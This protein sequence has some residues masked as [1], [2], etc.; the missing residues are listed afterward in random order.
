MKIEA[1]FL[2]VVKIE[3]LGRSKK[4]SEDNEIDQRDIGYENGRWM[5]LAQ[6]RVQW[7]ALVLALLNLWV[8]LQGL[9]KC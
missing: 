2:W 3:L 6:D 8:L 5:E 7:R 9:A 4:K 1:K